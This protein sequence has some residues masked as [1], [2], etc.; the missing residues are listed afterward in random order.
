MFNVNSSVDK[1]MQQ[2]SYHFC[3]G[4][5][6]FQKQIGFVHYWHGDH[7]PCWHPTAGDLL[8]PCLLRAESASSSGASLAE[9]WLPLPESVQ[10]VSSP[11]VTRSGGY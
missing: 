1:V 3:R 10:E 2:L 9:T 7:H 4:H 11:T 8:N 5:R 6:F